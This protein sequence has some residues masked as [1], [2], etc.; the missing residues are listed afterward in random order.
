MANPRL[1]RSM[2]IDFDELDQ[3]PNNVLLPL[4]SKDVRLNVACP[5]CKGMFHLASL[6][7]GV[8][9]KRRLSKTERQ[10]E[11]HVYERSLT[12]EQYLECSALARTEPH[13]RS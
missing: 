1:H 13:A 5:H 12:L 2:Q 11:A 3:V 9:K 8:W 4:I 6:V 10:C 7:H